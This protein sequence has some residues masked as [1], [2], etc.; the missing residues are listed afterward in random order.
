ME[1]ELKQTPNSANIVV[2]DCKQIMCMKK[3]FKYIGVGLIVLIA[4]IFIFAN[5]SKI[6]MSEKMKGHTLTLEQMIDSINTHLP[7]KGPDSLNF[8]VMDRVVL[9]DNNVVWEATLDTTFFYPIRESFLP[10]SLNGGVLTEGNRKMALELDTLLSNS[11]I[12][13]SHQLNLLYYYLFAKNTRPNPF[14]DEVIE[15][16]YSQTW[17]IHSPFSDRQYEYTMTFNKMKETEKFCKRQPEAA[18]KLF[19]SEYLKRQ[20]ILLTIAS[21][22][23]DVIMQMADEG[24]AIVFLCT[25]DKSYSVG[26]NKPISNLRNQKEEIEIVLE[27]DFRTLPIFY[28]TKNICKRTSK[29]FLFRFTDWDKNDSIEF[30]IY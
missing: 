3:V 30:K 7:S 24:S 1:R 29:V 27:E 12:Q 21:G 20:N 19:V 15:R 2:V 26:D 14:Y 13:K 4:A 28:D 8:F 17:R 18:L 5:I 11:L 25:F 22:N 23:A 16:K 10:E 9:E 6:I